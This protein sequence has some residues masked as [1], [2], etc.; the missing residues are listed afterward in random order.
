MGRRNKGRSVWSQRK[1]AT[2]VATTQRSLLGADGLT[3]SHEAL[4]ELRDEL[5]G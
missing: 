5:R 4:R 3:R 2:I 1:R